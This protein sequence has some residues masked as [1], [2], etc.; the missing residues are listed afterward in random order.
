MPRSRL[1]SGISKARKTQFLLLKILK[2]TKE[3]QNY[4]QIVK[5]LCNKCYIRNTIKVLEI[6]EDRVINS[7]RGGVI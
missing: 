5:I 7:A 3:R 4:E 1:E 6:R 2:F